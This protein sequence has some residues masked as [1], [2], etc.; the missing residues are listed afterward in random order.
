MIGSSMNPSLKHFVIVALVGTL[1]V[2]ACSPEATPTPVDL[3][4]TI[5]V[6]LASDMLTQTAVAYV[7]PPSPT[8][9]PA[10]DTPLPTETTIP[11]PTKDQ[12]S[13][14]IIIVKEVSPNPA[15]LF[16]PGESYKRVSFINTPKEVELLGTGNVPGWVVI[17]NPYFGSPCWLPLDSVEIDPALDLSLL[18][19]MAP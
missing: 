15:C 6:Q 4:A 14:R 9:L 3:A 19:V 5:A 2:T 8:A 16:G 10:T 13:L 7:P 11:E 12:E 18:P 1:I 17:K